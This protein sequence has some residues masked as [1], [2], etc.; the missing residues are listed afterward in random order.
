MSARHRLLRRGRLYGPTLFDPTV[1][2]QL[3]RPE[4][5]HAILD[6]QDDGQPRGVHFVS[7]NA[8]IKDQFEFVQQVWVNNPNFGGL[9]ANRDPLV[10][11]NDPSDKTGGMLV[12]GRYF[13]LRTSPLPR[14]VNVRGGA[15]LFMPGL[16]ALRYL[17]SPKLV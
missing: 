11:D 13:A 7:V 16:N 17:T 1:L 8:S 4:A 5:L 12:P 2:T 10:G 14:F 9:V 15:Y 6:L 3:D